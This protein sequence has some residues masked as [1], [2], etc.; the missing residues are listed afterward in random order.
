MPCR[1]SGQVISSLGGTP[2]QVSCPW[3]G[4]DGLR[5]AGIDAQASWLE[6]RGE[7]G[8]AGESA[9]PPVEP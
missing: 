8:G 5:K 3:C 7:K 9:A 1:G 4:G 2:V 6:A